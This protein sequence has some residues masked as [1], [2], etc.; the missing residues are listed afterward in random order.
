MKITKQNRDQI[1]DEISQK[2]SLSKRKIY[3]LEKMLDG[4]VVY[5][6]FTISIKKVSNLSRKLNNLGLTNAFAMN[7]GPNDTT[8]E[9]LPDAVSNY[10]IMR[11]NEIINAIIS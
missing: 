1:I 11:R 4:N 6:C 9:L 3:L 8:W 5:P 10:H 7:Y 2:I